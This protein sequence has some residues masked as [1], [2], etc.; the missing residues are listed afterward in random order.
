[1]SSVAL[2]CPIA[3]TVSPSTFQSV[4]AMVNYA[5][6]KGI[7]INHIGITERTLIETARNVLAKQ[8]LKTDN[9]WAM[10]IDAD[11]TFP[12]ETLVQLLETAKKKKAKMVSGIYY[13]RGGRHFPVAW[14]RDPKLEDGKKV[15]HEDEDRFNQNKYIGRFALPGKDAKEPFKL[16]TAGF[17]CVL[18]H[19]EVFETA[20]YPYFLFLPNKCSEDFYFFVNARENGYQLWADPRLDLYHIGDPPLIGKEDCYKKLEENQDEIHPI[21]N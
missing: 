10:W 3:E 4:I 13:Q 9:E 7:K 6:A 16:D 20:D 12:K 19:R 2:L 14:V 8:F 17:G 15:V 18:V 11:M 21:K 5:S 1:M